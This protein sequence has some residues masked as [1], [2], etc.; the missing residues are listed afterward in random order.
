MPRS[1]LSHR[2]CSP[3][4]GLRR[5]LSSSH[6]RPGLRRRSPRATQGGTRR[7]THHRHPGSGLSPT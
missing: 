7:R 3:D 2:G 4:P 6:L 1:G 5:S